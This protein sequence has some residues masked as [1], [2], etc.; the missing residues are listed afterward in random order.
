MRASRS[1]ERLVP[2]EEPAVRLA[3]NERCQSLV[4]VIPR[5]TKDGARGL[6]P[7]PS[8]GSRGTLY[9][10]PYAIGPR[11]VIRDELVGRGNHAAELQLRTMRMLWER[12]SRTPI[13]A[14]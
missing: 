11:V 8:R 1:G 10:G 9:P 14:G 4:H 6:E 12:A 3:T 5:N 2:R 7:R 13:L